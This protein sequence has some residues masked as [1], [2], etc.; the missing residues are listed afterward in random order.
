[1]IKKGLQQIENFINVA[2]KIFCVI[3]ESGSAKKVPWSKKESTLK[4]IIP[5]V[6]TDCDFNSTAE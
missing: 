3:D 2:Y 1:M 6:L 5:E 4:I